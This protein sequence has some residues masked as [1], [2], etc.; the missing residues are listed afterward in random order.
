MF[1]T[2]EDLFG[3]NN[4][5]ANFELNTMEEVNIMNLVNVFL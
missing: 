5:R 3:S 2:E 1:Q 4:F